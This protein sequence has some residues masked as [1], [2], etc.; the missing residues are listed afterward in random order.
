MTCTAALA[1]CAA[2]ASA[3]RGAPAPPAAASPAPASAPSAAR[4]GDEAPRVPRPKDARGI[5]TCELLTPAQLTALGLRPETAESKAVGTGRL[6]TWR[7]TTVGEPAG[8]TIADDIEV[9][10]LEHIYRLRDTFAVFESREVA[11]HPAVR[12]DGN[13]DGRC[14]LYVAVAEY[15]LL[16]ADGN[17]AGR[18]LPDPCERSR[19]MVEAVLSNL[20][21]LR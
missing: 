9:R 1:G 5:G 21:P 17:L 10:G 15:Q 6:C 16:S 11:G 3:D 19:R 8:I 18:P 20:P 4:S 7:S 14:S 2:P 12:A 13:A